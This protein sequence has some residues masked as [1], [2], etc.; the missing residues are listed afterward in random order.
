MGV[1]QSLRDQLVTHAADTIDVDV[2]CGRDARQ[3]LKFLTGGRIGEFERHG[4]GVAGET[5]I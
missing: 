4:L 3:T 5:R 1:V 2:G